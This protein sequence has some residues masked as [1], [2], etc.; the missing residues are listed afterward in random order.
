MGKENH[1]PFACSL[2]NGYNIQGWTMSAKTK[3]SIWISQLVWKGFKQLGHFMCRSSCH[4]QET[5]SE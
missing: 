2:P 5:G 1:L 4:Q 3:R